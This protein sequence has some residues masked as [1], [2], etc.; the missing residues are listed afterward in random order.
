MI[1]V[2]KCLLP[3]GMLFVCDKNIS[4]LNVKQDWLV[5]IKTNK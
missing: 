3:I 5:G 2:K 1:I 4:R